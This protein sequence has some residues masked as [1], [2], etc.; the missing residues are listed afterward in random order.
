MVRSIPIRS[1][2]RGPYSA[3]LRNSQNGAPHTSSAV[4][5]F[6][7]A[8]KTQLDLPLRAPQR[9]RA[10]P[11]SSGRRHRRAIEPLPL[12]RVKQRQAPSRWWKRVRGR[13]GYQGLTRLPLDDGFRGQDRDRVLGGN[14]PS[15]PGIRLILETAGHC[16]LTLYSDAHNAHRPRLTR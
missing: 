8:R 16:P 4:A 3:V 6:L 7:F 15:Q 13:H 10:A 11:R 12:K 5:L 2:R 1:Y 9:H 14:F